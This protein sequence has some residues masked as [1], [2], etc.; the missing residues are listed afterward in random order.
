MATKKKPD[1]KARQS[2]KNDSN[3]IVE[4]NPMMEL[5]VSGIQDMYWAENHLVKAL[6]KMK[7]ESSSKQLQSTI[8]DHL[9]VTKGHVSRLEQVFGLLGY[10]AR[11][12]KCDAMEGLTLEGEG[13][14]EDTIAGT[15]VRDLGIT[16]SCQKVEHYEIA[17]YNGLISLANFL[18]LPEAAE[19]LDANLQ[20][21]M[22]SLDLLTFMSKGI[23]E[24]ND[25]E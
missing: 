20:E 11:A 19:L 13:V 16:L 23:T 21:E 3:I 7:S 24:K 22:Q 4:I 2:E 12:R 8:A 18:G 1:T 10:K 5:F 17:S 25:T 9:E 6:P 14:I 15:T